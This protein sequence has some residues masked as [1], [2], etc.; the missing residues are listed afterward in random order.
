M[1][2][3]EEFAGFSRLAPA[4]W[5]EAPAHQQ[6]SGSCGRSTS[7]TARGPHQLPFHRVILG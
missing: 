2:L 4:L 6:F 1:L 3:V 7:L 5:M